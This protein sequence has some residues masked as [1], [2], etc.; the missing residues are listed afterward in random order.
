MSPG[1]NKKDKLWS[2][3]A[4]D[5]IGGDD[6]VHCLKATQKQTK[7][8]NSCDLSKTTA[9]FLRSERRDSDTFN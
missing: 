7:G 9:H 8:A 1:N 6:E 2:N 3:K 5:K 4:K